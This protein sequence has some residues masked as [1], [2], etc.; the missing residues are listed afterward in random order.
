M[1]K[2]PVLLLPNGNYLIYDMYQQKYTLVVV[3][4]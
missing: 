4:Q 1:K 2:E 3:K